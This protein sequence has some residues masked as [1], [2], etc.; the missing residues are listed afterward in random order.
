M[1]KWNWNGYLWDVADLI[2]FAEDETA[3]ETLATQL[4]LETKD[5]CQWIESS[6]KEQ[7]RSRDRTRANYYS[8]PGF[9][10]LPVGGT[11]SL[12]LVIKDYY[13]EAISWCLYQEMNGEIREIQR[14]IPIKSKHSKQ[15]V[16]FYLNQLL[17]FVKQYD[18]W[19]GHLPF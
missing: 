7:W 13:L 4:W 15:M 12:N 5:C 18:A 19:E 1:L 2:A 8:I 11:G 6:K 17:D 14:R 10:A 9:S 3:L 16:T